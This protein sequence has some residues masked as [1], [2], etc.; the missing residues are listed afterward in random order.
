MKQRKKKLGLQFPYLEHEFG[1]SLDFREMT[2]KFAYVKF[3]KRKFSIIYEY[4]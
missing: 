4:V 2:G 1:L 3:H